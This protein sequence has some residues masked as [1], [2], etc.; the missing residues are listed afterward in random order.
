LLN[1]AYFDNIRLNAFGKRFYEPAPERNV[2]VG[3]RIGL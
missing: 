1:T 2:Y 3:L